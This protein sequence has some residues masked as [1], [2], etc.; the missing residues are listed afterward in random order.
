MCLFLKINN[1]EPT[2]QTDEMQKMEYFE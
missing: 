1:V 2:L